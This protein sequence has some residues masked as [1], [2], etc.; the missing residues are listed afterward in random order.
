MSR[1]VSRPRAAKRKIH[2]KNEF[3]LCYLRHK[4]F[5]RV[6]YNPTPQEM[7]PFTHIVTHLAKNTYFRYQTLFELVG[8]EAEDVINIG[9]VHLVSFLGLFSLEK[10][11]SKYKEF[12]KVFKNIQEKAP[13][14]RD[15]LDKNQANFTLFLKQ[16]MQDV[17]RVCLQKA[18]NIKGIPH[19]EC[20]YYYGPKKPPKRLRELLKD[21]EKYGFK[22]ID[23]A[24]FKTIKKKAGLVHTSL[25]DFGGNY[26]VAL[27][28]ERRALR[29]EDFSG[30]GLD[31][32]DS[33]HN[34]TP[35]DIY[36]N[37]EDAEVWKKQK[38]EFGSKPNNIKADVIRDFIKKNKY[39]KEF[40]E[41]LK[42]ARKLLKGLEQSNG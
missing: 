5:R 42:T 6:K 38:E 30:A 40:S 11:P 1:Y 41:E 26:Y 25:F 15:I 13:K 10:M 3:E 29:L 21:H 17:V 7:K 16:R 20:R 23:P 24:V 33:L 9:M 27:S 39:N 18:R 19:E 2:S 37:M 28:V 4:Y 34:M 32:R 12:V 36:F 22:K 31:P 14:D 35:E 8:F